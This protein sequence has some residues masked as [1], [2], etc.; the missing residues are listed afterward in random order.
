MKNDVADMLIAI[1]PAIE[2]VTKSS[3]SMWSSNQSK[4]GCRGIAFPRY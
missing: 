4:E 1:S 3:L 2:D